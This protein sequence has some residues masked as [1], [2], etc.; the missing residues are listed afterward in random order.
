VRKPFGEIGAQNKTKNF[1]SNSV[2]GNS[3]KQKSQ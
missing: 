1:Q 3:S 2:A